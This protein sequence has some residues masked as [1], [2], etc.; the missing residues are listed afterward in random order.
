M[1]TRAAASAAPSTPR[2]GG[3]EI[4]G[5]G[6]GLGTSPSKRLPYYSNSEV[7]EHNVMTDCW[8]SYF[9]KVF[10]LT[11]L[12]QEN[13][14]LLVQPILKFAGQDIS[15][16]FDAKTHEPKTHVNPATGLRQPYTPYGRYLHIPPPEPTASWDNSFDVSWW[17]DHSRY[18]VGLLSRKKRSIKIINM[19][20]G[21]ED[22]LS[23]CAEESLSD[24]RER[25][26]AFNKH[27]M[28]YTWKRLGRVLNM[29][30]TL[31]ENDIPDQTEE[32]ANLNIDE[33]QYIPA[34]HV[35]FNDDLTA[36]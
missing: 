6:S 25:Y 2:L 9:G 30:L 8:V 5:G 3:S 26:I 21:Q 29:D 18:Q 23:V 33:D 27:A 7:A 11:S 35:Y 1:T 14:G 36:D 34:L 13:K 22:L 24:I 32:F 15:H 12:V 10:D 17:S 20:S 16:W 4:P 28:S 31:E 19:L